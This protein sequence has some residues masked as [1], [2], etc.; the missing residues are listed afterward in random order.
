MSKK[1]EKRKRESPSSLYKR[2]ISLERRVERLTGEMQAHLESGESINL[3][4]PP[5][6][7]TT[8]AL[9]HLVYMGGQPGKLK[10]EYNDGSKGKPF[11]LMV[12]WKPE[13]GWNWRPKYNLHL[14]VGTLSFRHVDYDKRVDVYLIRDKETRR[15]LQ[16]DV[17]ALAYERMKELLQAPQ[18]EG[19]SYLSIYQTGL[20]PLVI[21]LYR[22]L[23][24]HLQYRNQAGLGPLR[25]QP[26]FY[27]DDATGRQATGAIWGTG[28]L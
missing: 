11:P 19:E 14:H 23:T 22:A 27:W 17:E 10:I 4:I 21:G 25:V 26:V 13:E 2:T 9:H 6:R 15:L 3:S 8:E 28:M 24:E 5:H 7:E 16:A 18:L 20:E 12:L 1:R